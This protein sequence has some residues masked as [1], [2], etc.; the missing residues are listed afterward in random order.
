VRS[1]NREAFS[2]N[3]RLL[4]DENYNLAATQQR[5][6]KDIPEGGS[7]GTILL[8]PDRQDRPRDAFEKYVDSILD[9]VTPSVVPGIKDVRFFLSLSLALALA[10]KAK[11]LIVVI[12]SKLL[13]NTE[14]KSSFSLVPTKELLNTWIG[15]QNTLAQGPFSFPHL[16]LDS[17]PF[18]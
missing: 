13:T 10:L 18:P 14:R 6:N 12:S 11:S 17:F 16:Q 1:Q 15:L 4:F 7:K 5:K 2:I 3:C 9:L 8:N